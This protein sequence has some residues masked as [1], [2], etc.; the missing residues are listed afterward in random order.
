M[1]D[2]RQIVGTLYQILVLCSNML[3]LMN[4]LIAV[5]SETYQRFTKFKTG[6][7]HKAII[8]RMPVYKFEKSYSCLI[9]APAPLNVLVVPFLPYFFISTNVRLTRWVNK[10]VLKLLYLPVAF[11]AVTTFFVGNLICLPLA[12][13]KALFHKM[14][15]LRRLQ[16][17]KSL[18]SFIS[19]SWLG[20]PILAIG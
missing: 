2:Q 3:L 1:D 19:F 18:S 15:I 17:R 6:L 9:S 20:F 5:M 13:V 11:V 14:L 10:Q 7:L 4:L 8:F 16:T 12:F